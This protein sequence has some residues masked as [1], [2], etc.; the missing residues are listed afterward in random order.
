MAIIAD[1]LIKKQTN[2]QSERLLFSFPR[3]YNYDSHFLD[4]EN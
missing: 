3:V 2:K 4:Y 1:P